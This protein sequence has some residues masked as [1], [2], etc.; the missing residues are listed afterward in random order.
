MLDNKKKQKSLND[1]I[2]NEV[3]KRATPF[4]KAPM[5]SL[6][7]ALEKKASE[8]EKKTV[9]L[10]SQYA[11]DPGKAG[12]GDEIAV[13]GQEEWIKDAAFLIKQEGAEFY[14][15]GMMQ[16]LRKQFGGT[17][18]LPPPTRTISAPAAAARSSASAADSQSRAKIPVAVEPSATTT[19]TGARSRIPSGSILREMLGHRDGGERARIGCG[20][21]PS[22]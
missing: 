7:R 3:V 15:Q 14:L 20:A 1:A 13:I 5:T 12:L 4:N 22:S 18:L 2:L 8:I 16:A 19:G 10:Y 11:Y 9:E 17:P 6:A 21:K